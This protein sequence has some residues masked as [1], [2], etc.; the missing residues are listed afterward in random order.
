MM[1]IADLETH[2]KC[3]IVRKRTTSVSAQLLSMPHALKE[4]K[5]IFEA[6]MY[7]ID[8]K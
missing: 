5:M 6:L 2:S 3:T 1:C 4:V 7:T 8:E